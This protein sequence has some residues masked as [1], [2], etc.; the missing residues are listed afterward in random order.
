M[1]NEKS[2]QRK[3]LTG[4]KDNVKNKRKSNE[5]LSSFRSK[6]MKKVTLLTLSNYNTIAVSVH[7]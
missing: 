2:V 6:K 4:V 3:N 1:T 7:R 5:T